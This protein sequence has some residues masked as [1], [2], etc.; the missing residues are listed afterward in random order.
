MGNVII[1]QSGGPTAVIN[2]SLAGCISAAEKA[3]IS[4]IY[5]MNHGI[6]GFLQDDIVDLK[7]AFPDS[8]AL[9]LLKRTPSAY[10][11][12]CRYKLPDVGEGSEIY[13]R[14]FELLEKHDI[15]YFLY[16]GG[17]DSM[18]TICKLADYAKE[19][20]KPQKFVGVPKTID[21]DLPA[22]D[23]TPGYGSAAK[24]IATT[25][26]EIVRDN[27]SFG[28]SEPK[29][30]I[31]EIMGRNAGWLTAASALARDTDCI[32][33]DLIYLPEVPFNEEDFVNRVK[34]LAKEK[35]SIVVAVSEGIRFADGTL[36]CEQG[37]DPEFLD[38]F[39]HKQ[40]SG[41]GKV[42]THMVADKIGYKT[43]CVEFSIIQRCASHLASRVDVDEAYNVGFEAFNAA[44]RGE[45]GS[46]IVIKVNEREP[47]VAV[48][49]SADIH[50]IAN[51]EKMMPRTMITE[52][53][54]WVTKEF[55][56]YARPL[57]NGAVI[58]YYSA[59]VPTHSTQHRPKTF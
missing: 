41:S 46:M 53:G 2:S 19:H 22:T 51:F 9:S 49:E 39:G 12:T 25:V 33:P 47:Y 55:T 40:L 30:T 45:S 52:D 3:G 23:H 21:N 59:G 32:G 58:P 44:R 26:K 37:G 7:E 34:E 1:G 8:Y 54:T 50:D 6:E 35:Y 28:A 17:N 36:V 31:V 4:G 16:I 14:I 56:D 11:G 38:A 57:I 15:E 5:G 27:E 18:D 10:L 48:Y 24:F 13:G 43:R 20:G 42:L 29:L